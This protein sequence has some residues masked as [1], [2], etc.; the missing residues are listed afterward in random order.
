MAAL[1]HT[2][3][4]VPLQVTMLIGSLI[5]L[6]LNGPTQIFGMSWVSQVNVGMD[7]NK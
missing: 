3:G 2:I 6:V 4:C 5:L 7:K 1:R